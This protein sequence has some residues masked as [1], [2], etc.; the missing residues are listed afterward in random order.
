M[1]KDNIIK[2]M[3]KC[4]LV[5]A[6]IFSFVFLFTTVKATDEVNP[7]ARS[8]SEEVNSAAK[9]NEVFDT[10]A[11][12]GVY[13]YSDNKNVIDLPFIRYATDRLIID[14]ELSGLGTS[15]SSKTIEVN[16]PTTGIQCL[17]ATDTVRINADMEYAII[18]AGSNIIIN[19]NITKSVIIFGG[20]NV[21]FEE[22]AKISGDVICYSNNLDILGK[23][24]GSI[25]GAA[26]KINVK[27]NIGKDLRIQTNNINIEDATKVGG[28]VYIET[29]SNELKIKD[30]FPDATVKVLE[31]KQRRLTMP[32]VMTGITT[33]L[34]YTLLF[35]II[36]RATKG[37]FF[38]TMVQ[39]TRQHVLFMVV[40]G[41][42]SLL[43]MIPLTFL[44]LVLAAIGLS[45]I[46]IPLLIAY[47]AFE[48]VIGLLST[49][50]VGSLI[51][52]HMS[53]TYFKDQSSIMNAISTFIIFGVL[54]TLARVP[55]VG[56]YVTLLL[57]FIGIGIAYTV[58][59]TKIKKESNQISKN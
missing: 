48:I 29:Y 41:A 57:L 45:A 5:L 30:M 35:V 6:F 33:C 52:Q 15:F 49:F 47:Y 1:I 43:L 42:G 18:F 31:S 50:V 12:D 34:L 2:N 20:A 14:K 40:M 28:N 51:A 53:N 8:N 16:S 38:N 11:V 37:K 46:A 26:N 56:T 55:V 7:Y 13:R 44:L 24:D 58:I 21:T 27:G 54:Y 59:F 10:K 32:I 23:I 39:K 36:K 22:N 4:T 3:K 9:I 25:L 19:S 17:F